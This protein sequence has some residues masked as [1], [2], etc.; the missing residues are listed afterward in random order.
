MT[1]VGAYYMKTE[2][3][4]INKSYDCC[5]ELSAVFV[6]NMSLRMTQK[7]NEKCVYFTYMEI[8]CLIVQFKK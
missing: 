5:N 8:S 2:V 6:W 7:R 3:I 1:V 4:T